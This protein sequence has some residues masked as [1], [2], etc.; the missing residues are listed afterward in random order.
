M[1]ER[2]RVLRHHDFRNLWVAQSA[3]AMGDGVV[4]VALALFVTDLTDNPTDVGIVLFAQ[5]VPLVSFLLIG[6][7]WADRLPRARVMMSADVAR[8]GLHGLLAILIF[9]DTVEIWHMVVIEACFGTAQAF[10]EPAYTGLLPRTVPAR[11]VQD[12]QALSGF[13][14]NLAEL[15]GPAIATA[16]VLGLGA[17]WAFLLDAGTFFLSALFLS[18]VHAPETA[19]GERRTVLAELAEG[20]REVRSRA[21]LWVTVVV[22][23]LA[24]PVGYAPLYVLGPTVAEETYDSTAVFGVVTAAYGAGALVGALIGFRWR[25]RHPMRAAFLVIAVW[26]VMLVGFATGVTIVLVVPLAVAT[27]VGFALFDVF[28]NTTMAEQIPPH[29]LSRASAWEWMGSLVLLPVGYLAAGPLAEATSTETVLV[30]GAA[31]TAAVLALGLLP[32]ETRML[33]RAEHA[34]FGHGSQ[35]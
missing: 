20:F 33:R 5:L 23:A 14:F 10:S 21:W 6:G 35:V 18:H 12:A 22:F 8:A 28:W 32:R 15:T 3:S 29:A 31:L 34:G 27:G 25:P 30:G 13:T 26:P 11:E 9:T 17:G 4:V 19:L 7:V 1:R 24:V 2:L 16:L